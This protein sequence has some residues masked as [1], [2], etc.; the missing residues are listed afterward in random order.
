MPLKGLLES[1]QMI[2]PYQQC[3]SIF[4]KVLKDNVVCYILSE[5]RILVLRENF[6]QT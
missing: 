3:S 5:S 1:L 4:L 6:K 2:Y